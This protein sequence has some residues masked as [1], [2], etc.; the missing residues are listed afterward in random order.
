MKIALFGAAFDP[1]HLGHLT[2]A[3]SVLHQ[4]LADQIW[5]VPAKQHAFGKLLSDPQNRLQLLSLLVA[6]IR[7]QYPDLADK[8]KISTYELD[9]AGTSYTYQTLQA[10]QANFPHDQFV[11]VMGSDNLA[12]F[13]EWQEQSVLAQFPF[14]IYPR[15]GYPLEPLWPNMTLMTGV[16]TVAISST[17]IREK[18]QRGETIHDLVPEQIEEYIKQNHLYQT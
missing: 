1:P 18:I 15:T 13:N 14:Y 9:Q 7:Q 16:E 3:V 2:V 8:I 12:R 6:S 17:L 4:N 11:F 5:L 10:L